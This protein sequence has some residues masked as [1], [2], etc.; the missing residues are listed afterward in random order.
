MELSHCRER[1]LT[2]EMLTNVT[3]EGEIV[4]AEETVEI[5]D[6][7]KLTNDI[8]LADCPGKLAQLRTAFATRDSTLI[9]SG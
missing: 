1:H 8:F 7:A 9:A 3:P 4:R 6:A 2:Y 5:V